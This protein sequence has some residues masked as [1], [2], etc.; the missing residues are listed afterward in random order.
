MGRCKDRKGHHWGIHPAHLG[1]FLSGDFRQHRK[2]RKSRHQRELEDGYSTAGSLGW[3]W[4]ELGCSHRERHCGGRS[5]LHGSWGWMKP[6][7]PPQEPRGYYDTTAFVDWTLP[8][9][10]SQRLHG[11]GVGS[12]GTY[13]PIER[14][15]DS[16]DRTMRPERWCYDWPMKPTWRLHSWDKHGPNHV[17]MTGGKESCNSVLVGLHPLYSLPGCQ[18]RSPVFKNII[19]P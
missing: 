15:P 4:T 16:Y 2:A 6:Q 8:F 19:F 11:G 7:Y 1:N 5:G 14:F 13:Y 3:S 9:D 18:W 17:C 12:L 10:H